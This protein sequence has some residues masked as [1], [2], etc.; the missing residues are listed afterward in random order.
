M[1]RKQLV[2]IVVV[3]VIPVG[4]ATIGLAL[5]GLGVLAAALLIIEVGVATAVFVA[6]R[7]PETPGRPSARPWLVPTV[8]VGSLGL[9]VV[10]A[11]VAAH[12]G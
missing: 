12:A 6:R 5:A 8:M 9:M 11:V 3:Y 10:V 1:P 7:R 2:P 4:L